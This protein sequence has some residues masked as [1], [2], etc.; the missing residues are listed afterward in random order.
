MKKYIS[1]S[2]LFAVLLTG[3]KDDFFDQVVDVDVPEHTPALAITSEISNTDTILWAY[4]SNSVGILVQDNPAP[5]T[6]AKVE[7]YKNGNLLEALPHVEQGFYG[8]QIPEPLSNDGAEY[9]LRVSKDGFESVSA[10]QEMPPQVDLISATYEKEGTVDL[11]G[12]RVDEYK[13][14]F[15]DERSTENYYKVEVTVRRTYDD[16]AQYENNIYTESFDPSVYTIDGGLYMSDAVFDGDETEVS[17]YSYEN[18]Y[19]EN[20]DEEV[21]LSIRLVHITK[22]HYFRKVSLYNYDPE[23]PFAEPTVVFSNVENGHGI[24]SMEATGPEFV[25]PL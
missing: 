4:V 10:V 24:F 19:T 8:W 22:E 7:L 15:Q 17:F 5:I 3:C 1:F 2:L 9:E 16:G 12:Y 6:D 18:I 25:I 23:N 14:K 11:E 21:E 20:P 13:I